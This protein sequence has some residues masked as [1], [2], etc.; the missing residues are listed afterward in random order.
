LVATVATA[1][2]GE[3]STA[4]VDLSELPQ[5]F[6]NSLGME[7]VLIPGGSFEMGRDLDFGPGIGMH[8]GPRHPVTVSPYY[9]SRAEVTKAQYRRYVEATGEDDLPELDPANRGKENDWLWDMAPGDHY[10][11]YAAP[12]GS[13]HRFCRWLGD[14]EDT[15]YRLPTEAEWEFACRAGSDTPWWWGPSPLPG[16]FVHRF[17]STDYRAYAGSMSIAGAYPANPYGLWDVYSNAFEWCQD[18]FDP[19]YFKRSPVQ[20]PEGPWRSPNHRRVVRGGWIGSMEEGID[21]YFRSGIPP[22]RGF[23]GIRLVLP[24]RADFR[25]PES[26]RLPEPDPPPPDDPP[27]PTPLESLE[28]ELGNGVTM[29]F[30]QVPPGRFTMGSPEDELGRGYWE[31]PQTEVV[32]TQPYYLARYELTNAQWA[33]MRGE[34]LPDGVVADEPLRAVSW[35]TMYDFLEVWNERERA[36]GRLPAGAEYR[37]PYEYEWEYAYRA[38][39]E[40]RFPHGEA[41]EELSWYAV[42]DHLSGPLAVGSRRPNAWGFYDMGG[43]VWDWC[44]N[45]KIEY[46]GGEIDGDQLPRIGFGI[47]RIGRGGGYNFGWIASRSAMRQFFRTSAEFPWVGFRLVRTMAPEGERP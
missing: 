30:L 1:C 17:I 13:G 45:P 22:E 2:R 46:P 14:A 33:A 7:M 21:S 5:R 24:I 29:E 42:Y 25:L 4:A 11:I 27:P 31:G 28:V 44:K 3:R 8:D 43:N 47:F 6:I 26:S 41:I 39:S 18:W 10:P 19:D 23:G 37:L 34:P 9:I 32:I 36:A 16:S 15:T 40:T 12:W 38:G 20:D 35:L